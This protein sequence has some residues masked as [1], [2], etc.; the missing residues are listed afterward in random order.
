MPESISTQGFLRRLLTTSLWLS[1]GSALEARAKLESLA[2][3]LV[4]H[5][6]DWCTVDLRAEGARLERV[7]TVHMDAEKRRKAHDLSQRYPP[8]EDAPS[9]PRKVIDSGE[10]EF[11]PVVSRE[12]LQ[13]A[14]HDEEHLRLVEELGLASYLCVPLRSE[15]AV[16]GALTVVRSEPDQPFTEQERDLVVALGQQVG[17]AVEDARTLGAELIEGQRRVRDL[18]DANQRYS[19]FLEST[20][21]AFLALDRQWNVVFCNLKVEPLLDRT[22]SEVLGQNFW[23]VFPQG[24]GTR[25]QSKIQK[26]AEQREPLLFEEFYAPLGRWFQVQVVP[27]AD[28]LLLYFYDITQRRQFEQA[29]RHSEERFRAAVEAVGD[30]IWTNTAEGEMQGEQPYWAEFTGQSPEQYSGLGWAQ[31]VHPEDAPATLQAWNEAVRQ[32]RMMSVEHR[33]RRRDGVYRLFSV[34]AVPVFNDDQ[35]LREWVG[36][37]TDITERRQREAERQELLVRERVARQ[38]AETERQ[39]AAEATEQL[40]RQR[41]EL[42]RTNADIERANREL[43]AATAELRARQE[44]Q[45]HITTALRAVNR[46]GAYLLF[47]ENLDEIC[48]SVLETLEN[49]F[50][51][52]VAGVW[53]ATSASKLKRQ[54]ARGIEA[55]P[56]TALAAELDL[57]FDSYKI[58]WVARYRRPF[59]SGNLENDIQFDQAWLQ[60]HG[61]TSAALFPLL[62]GER[63]LGVLALF[64][65]Q[66]LPV[67]AGEILATLAALLSAS[68]ENVLSV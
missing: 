46:T 6:A 56:T 53:L 2:H 41:D 52:K 7:I 67:E 44:H 10:P 33:L 19:E 43:N 23:S 16:I 25:F 11:V 32:R 29:V 48:N 50:R 5:F 64:V 54:A 66:P 30:I 36:V 38:Q 17:K 58:A 27:T 18:R 39:R 57:N 9:G 3:M 4:P 34:R 13:T 26:T 24:A 8:R 1:G 49:A 47:K 28:H 42:A 40:A 14:V 63:F 20:I 12:L 15:D 22:R 68:L 51:A 55:A 60:E 21:F 35:G 59:V 61:I 62:A 65:Q 45:L 37:H 31:A